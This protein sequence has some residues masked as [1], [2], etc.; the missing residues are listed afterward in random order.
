MKLKNEFKYYL[1]HNIFPSIPL[2]EFTSP[3][4]LYK[5]TEYC[6][7]NRLCIGIQSIKLLESKTVPCHFL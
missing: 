2:P 7:S 6:S 1:F 3:T 4:W 5:T